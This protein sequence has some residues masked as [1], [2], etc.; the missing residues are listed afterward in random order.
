MCVCMYVCVCVHV[1]VHTCMCVHACDVC[2]HACDVCMHACDVCMHACD[3]CMHVCVCVH[4]LRDDTQLQKWITYYAKN[5]CSNFKQ[6]IS[7]CQLVL[8]SMW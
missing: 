2:M 5:K 3:V 1:C 4:V 8:H 6:H 7:R